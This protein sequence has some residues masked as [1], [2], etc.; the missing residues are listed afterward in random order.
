M[1][2]LPGQEQ[3]R[4]PG[5]RRPGQQG[6]PRNGPPGQHRDPAPGGHLVPRPHEVATVGRA[7]LAAIAEAP[8]GPAYG[9]RSCDDYDEAL[10]LALDAY[11]VTEG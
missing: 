7:A 4:R 3:Q 5:A 8:D 10:Q 9:H 11:A 6:H 2:E 1:T